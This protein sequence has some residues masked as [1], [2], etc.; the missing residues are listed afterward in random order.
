MKK[1]SLKMMK[2]EAGGKGE[3]STSFLSLQSMILRGDFV[4]I[5]AKVLDV[6]G[7]I[8]LTQFRVF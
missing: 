7:L 3:I 5:T 8:L 2:E 4:S 6:A 1:N